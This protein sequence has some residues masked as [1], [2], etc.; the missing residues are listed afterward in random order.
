MMAHFLVHSVTNKSY[1]TH[2]HGS[3]A[4]SFIVSSFEH[5]AMCYILNNAPVIIETF[6]RKEFND[7]VY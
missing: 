7:G 3:S 5:N 4:A 6:Q 1:T 2:A